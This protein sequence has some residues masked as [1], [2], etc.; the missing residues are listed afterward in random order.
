VVAETSL[1]AEVTVETC[2]IRRWRG[3]VSSTFYAVT[4]TGEVLAE[5]SSF[6]WRKAAPPPDRPAARRA[7]DEVVAAL[8]GD[9]WT[10]ATRGAGNWFETRL[11]RPQTV[12]TAPVQTPQDVAV[13]RPAVTHEPS[14]PDPPDPPAPSAGAP[15]EEDTAA[16]APAAPPAVDAPRRHRHR[17][18]AIGAA[19]VTVAAVAV[20]A[21]PASRYV[22][23]HRAPVAQVEPAAKHVLPA[24]NAAPSARERAY[25]TTRAAAPR[26]AHKTVDVRIRAHGNGSW[27]EVRSGSSKGEL[28][29]AGVL[30]GGS[31]LHFR[32]RRLWTRFGAAANLSVAVDGDSVSLQGTLEKL[33][34][35]S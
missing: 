28:L 35:P 9:G 29:Y 33:F 31:G 32:S 19:A 2:R 14:R 30:P 26:G 7:H 5:S 25:V 11:I 20:A 17:R 34:V 4:D 1:R 15:V 10:I 23:K 13:A 3:Y 8:T 12:V 16:A 24:A 21:V 6:R 22:D 18:L 27:I